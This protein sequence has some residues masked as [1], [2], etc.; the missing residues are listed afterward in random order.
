MNF[1]T[2]FS[3]KLDIRS[4]CDKQT[5]NINVYINFLTILEDVNGVLSKFKLEEQE[6]KVREEKKKGERR[7]GEEIAWS[8]LK[9][10]QNLQ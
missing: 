3:L 7:R 9:L 1:K 5:L 2:T 6:R 8:E 10:P 4:I